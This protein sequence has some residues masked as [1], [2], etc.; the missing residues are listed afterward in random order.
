MSRSD[1]FKTTPSTKDLKQPISQWKELG[2]NPLVA[3]KH[4]FFYF[5]CQVRVLNVQ[6]LK[7]AFTNNVREILR[8]GT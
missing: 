8:R 6:A 1:V 3:F 7:A 5:K 4:S 2:F